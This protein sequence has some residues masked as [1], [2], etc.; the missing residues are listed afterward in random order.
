[1]FYVS[2]DAKLMSAALK[3]RTDSVEVSFPHELFALS[4]SSPGNSGI[5]VYT[6]TP[7]GQRFLINDRLESTEPL[8]VV[9]NWPSLLRKEAGTQ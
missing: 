7:D 5:A 4:A 8:H 1:M 2:R 6:V 9:V 3:L